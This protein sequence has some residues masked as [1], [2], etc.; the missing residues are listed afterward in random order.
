VIPV[1]AK[2][3]ATSMSNAPTTVDPIAGHALWSP[4]YDQTL[5]PVLALEQRL[6]LLELGHLSG[7]RLLDAGC[8]TGRW[9]DLARERGALAA[10]IDITPK[11]LTEAARKPGV[12]G[13]IAEADT[14]CLPFAAGSFSLAVCAFVF[15]YVERQEE[16]IRELA[17]VVKPG[18]R[19]I[20]SD[21]HPEALRRRWT[22]S[23]R[24]GESVYEIQ[25]RRYSL[26][27]IRAAAC[28]Q[29]L[30]ERKL[31]EAHFG[32]PERSIFLRAGKA[33]RFDEV[34]GIPAVFVLVWERVT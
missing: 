13:R 32:E 27:E 3:R 33:E 28:S 23:F 9:M 10:G 29:G 20:L 2:A 6:L 17:R 11:I 30:Q 18:G 26:G 31:V 22:S 19:I 25:R 4:S 7:Q 1:A 21:L 8:G 24:S 14:A 34:T 5:N 16:T 12:Q 15:G